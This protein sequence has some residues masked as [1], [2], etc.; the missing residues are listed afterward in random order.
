MSNSYLIIYLHGFNSSSRSHKAQQLRQLVAHSACG[1]ELQIP[2]LSH[3]PLEAI[4]QAERLIGAARNRRVCLVGSSLGGFYASSLA[5]RHGLRAVLINPAVEPWDLLAGHRGAQTNPA[6]GEQYE[7]GEECLQQ[8]RALGTPAIRD[9][10]HYLV[11][12]TRGDELLDHR[13]ALVRFAGAQIVLREGGDHAYSD[14]AADAAD[15]V[16][17]CQAP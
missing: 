16:A 6:T 2:T 12:L 10:R 17:F 4:A 7:L 13:Q 14:F 8:L 15:V 3:R 9:P 11:L 1:F 5:E